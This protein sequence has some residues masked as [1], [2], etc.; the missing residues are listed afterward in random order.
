MSLKEAF[1]DWWIDDGHWLPRMIR[2]WKYNRVGLTIYTY[3][4]SVDMYHAEYSHIPRASLPTDA[5]HVTGK[6]FK[7]FACDRTN[8]GVFPAPGTCTAIDL[9]LYMQTSAFDEALTFR[10][11]KTLDI[12]PRIIVV[13]AIAIIGLALFFFMR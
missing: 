10:K 7:E 13:G 9:Y 1:H 6:H 4:A 3:D 8:Q 11:K 12:D 2:D 5:L